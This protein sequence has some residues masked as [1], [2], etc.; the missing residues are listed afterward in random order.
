[1]VGN[2]PKI[3]VLN[4]MDLADTS[5][6]EVEFVVLPSVVHRRL[7]TAYVHSIQSLIPAMARNGDRFVMLTNCKEQYHSS[8]KEVN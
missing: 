4:K 6:T 1:M 8:I 2:R 5:K 7:I 3:L